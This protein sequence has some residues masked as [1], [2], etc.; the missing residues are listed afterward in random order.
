[1]SDE[2]KQAEK[3]ARMYNWAY[4]QP[5]EH[6]VIPEEP[7]EFEEF[8]IK[9]FEGDFK[10]TFSNQMK[11]GIS[12]AIIFRFYNIHPYVFSVWCDETERG[13]QALVKYNRDRLDNYHKLCD[14]LIKK[15]EMSLKEL[16]SHLRKVGIAADSHVDKWQ[17][18]CEREF[19]TDN[20]IYSALSCNSDMPSVAASLGVCPY[21]LVQLA[22]SFK[23]LS[24]YLFTNKMLPN[25]SPIGDMLGGK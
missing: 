11:T 9:L 12:S 22:A 21:E 3:E 20:A 8:G 4:N 5:Y 25:F 7:E 10:K 1:M 16:Q 19:I 14:K 13:K 15:K 17:S 18:V 23:P 24:D 2:K 6:V